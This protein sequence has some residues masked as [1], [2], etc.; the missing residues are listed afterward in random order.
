M[1]LVMFTRCWTCQFGQCFDSPKP[2]SWMDKEDAEHA[3]HPWPLSTGVADANLCACECAGGP[4]GCV[5]VPDGAIPLPEDHTPREDW[6]D[7]PVRPVEDVPTR[8]LL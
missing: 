5:T 7:E 3:G 1:A 6:D 4:G 8:G 2:H